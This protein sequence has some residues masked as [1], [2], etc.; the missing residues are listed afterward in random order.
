MQLHADFHAHRLETG[1]CPFPSIVAGLL[2]A[3]VCRRTSRDRRLRS[4]RA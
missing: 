2:L 4:N 3:A 1:G